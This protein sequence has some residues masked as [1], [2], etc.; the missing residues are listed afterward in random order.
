MKLSSKQNLYHFQ[1]T[2]GGQYV[3][4]T[5]AATSHDSDPP[6][7]VASVVSVAG[8]IIQAVTEEQLT[9]T[10]QAINRARAIAMAEDEGDEVLAWVVAAE[11]AEVRP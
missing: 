7:Y 1:T 4:I 10:L 6:Q 11:R 2:I 3:T 5:V 8:E 9:A